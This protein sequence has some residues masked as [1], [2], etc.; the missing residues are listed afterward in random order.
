[1]FINEFI[2]SLVNVNPEIEINSNVLSFFNVNLGF[3]TLVILN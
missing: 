2:D 3:S 1:M